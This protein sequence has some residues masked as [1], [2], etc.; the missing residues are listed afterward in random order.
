MSS[1][2]P[3][4]NDGI[5]GDALARAAAA[6]STLPETPVLIDRFAGWCRARGNTG[7]TVRAYR[8]DAEQFADFFARRKPP[9]AV[10]DVGSSDARAF[11]GSLGDGRYDPATVI[12]KLSALRTFWQYLTSQYGLPDPM[13]GITVPKLAP[14]APQFLQEIAI[15]KILRAAKDSGDHFQTKRDLALL[16]C[17]YATGMKVNEVAALAVNDLRLDGQDGIGSVDIHGTNPRILPLSNLVMRILRS[18]IDVRAGLKFIS[19]DASQALWV[20]RFGG[21]LSTRSIRKLLDKYVAKAGLDPDAISPNTLRHS[22]A[23]HLLA[24]GVQLDALQA[25]LGHRHFSTTRAYERIGTLPA[26]SGVRAFLPLF[27][28]Q[29]A[30]H[31]M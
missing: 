14:R 26:P 10:R 27:D 15:A 28:G 30:S 23:V 31:P 24:R 2:S 29:Q 18:W 3:C 13:K 17:M 12:R 11:V 19:P 22:F 20:N 5:A 25:L 4:G 21:R 6:P 8:A 7:D 16:M 9:T 1:I